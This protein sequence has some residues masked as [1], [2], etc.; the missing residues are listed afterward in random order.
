MNLL[1]M[2][3][4]VRGAHCARACG[5]VFVCVCLCVWEG[6]CVG[7]YVY[8]C[9]FMCAYVCRCACVYV[10]VRVCVC[11]YIHFNAIFPYITTTNLILIPES[12]SQHIA[13]LGALYATI[14][15]LNI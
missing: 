5:C 1:H 12:S 9:V 15:L 6:G 3:V 13:Q 7:G 10:C 11:A 4:C 8:V 14:H 2:S